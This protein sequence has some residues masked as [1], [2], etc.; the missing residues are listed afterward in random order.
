M[1]VQLGSMETQFFAY[2]QLRRLA[3]V[4]IGE[5]T[6]PLGISQQQERELLS[7]LAR[8]GLIARVRR[9]LY[10]VPDRLPAGGT[11]S[12]G[13]ALALNTLMQ[14]CGAVYQVCG[15]NA[16]HRYGWDT[17]IP[18]RVYV[19]NDR[20]SGDRDVGRI[21]FSF[22]KLAAARL[23]ATES[24]TSPEGSRVFYC[25]RVRS[26]VDA[27]HDWSRFDSLP[28][29]YDWI[30]L[31]LEKDP[32]IASQLVVIAIRYGNM[33]TRRRLGRLLESLDAEAS[34]LRKLEKRVSSSSASIP[35]IPSRPKRGTVHR[36]WGVIVNE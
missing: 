33:S 25:S 26:L 32:K 30:R 29:G 5:L 34:V 11:W 20:L 12:P 10:L 15:P 23:G 8:R 16:F 7:R 14:D 28:R 27:I 36:R 24:V 18:N 9:G 4:R 31:E 35:W 2:V 17:Q 22:I 3:A 1:P 21:Q 6:Q 19:Y 13:E